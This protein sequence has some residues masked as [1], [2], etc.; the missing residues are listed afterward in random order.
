VCVFVV[1]LVYSPVTN[2]GDTKIDWLFETFMVLVITG[3]KLSGV[4]G[5]EAPLK[6]SWQV[7]GRVSPIVET[8]VLVQPTPVLMAAVAFELAVCAKVG[9]LIIAAKVKV[10]V[11]SA[12][13]RAFIFSPIRLRP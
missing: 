6:M 5:T 11:I 3:T 7:T 12:V 2:D 10:I 1:V 13:P 9:V 4:T 8:P